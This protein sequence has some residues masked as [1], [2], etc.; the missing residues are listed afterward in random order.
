MIEVVAALTVMSLIPIS[1]VAVGWEIFQEEMGK[2]RISEAVAYN[3]PY[4]VAA[5]AE[6]EILLL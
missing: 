1:M 4:L 3:D 6:V 5:R 2:K